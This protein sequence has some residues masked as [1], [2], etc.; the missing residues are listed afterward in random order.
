MMV[1]LQLRPS[2]QAIRK[3]GKSGPAV[4]AFYDPRP[5]FRGF[6]KNINAKAK[7]SVST[8]Q[9][10]SRAEGFAKPMSLEP[11]PSHRPWI[12]TLGA[13]PAHR[14]L[15]YHAGVTI[16]S[17]QTGFFSKR[18]VRSCRMRSVAG[19]T[20]LERLN[21]CAERKPGAAAGRPSSRSSF[22]G[23]P[24]ARFFKKNRT[25]S[26]AEKG[27]TRKSFEQQST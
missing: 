22:L 3:P 25:A 24:G 1:P 27:E 6:T 17:G 20:T 14:G 4:F 9:L 7:P 13:T 26:K 12:S 15:R 11:A 18:K 5:P 23:H 16:E 8:S 21:G 2:F 10:G 19:T